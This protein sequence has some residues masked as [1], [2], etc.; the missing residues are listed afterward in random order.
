[1][2]N[3]KVDMA[4][5]TYF[6]DFEIVVARYNENVDWTYQFENV[7]IYDKCDNSDLKE[8]G[9]KGLYI[10]GK[11]E[12]WIIKVKND[13]KNEMVDEIDIESGEGGI[14]IREFKNIYNLKIA[15]IQFNRFINFKPKIISLPNVGRESQTYLHHIIQKYDYYNFEC[16][17]GRFG[18]NDGAVV[19]LQGHPFDHSPNIIK[20]LYKY[21]ENYKELLKE[22]QSAR[23]SPT[24]DGGEFAY[25]GETLHVTNILNPRDHRN[26]KWP[27]RQI[28][29][30]LFNIKYEKDLPTADL[31]F[32]NGAQFIVSINTILSNDIEFYKQMIQHVSKDVR[33]KAGFVFERLWSL[34]FKADKL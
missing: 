12:L 19:F 22:R 21:K 31:E 6:T 3:L 18:R 15:T 13:L 27:L 4:N 10:S 28:Y 7:Y 8:Y 25:L 30:Q 9:F 11:N 17:G 34:V 14:V 5:P 33:P 20:N 23:Q 24:D 32:Y 29:S 16:G 1:M 26:I 2:A